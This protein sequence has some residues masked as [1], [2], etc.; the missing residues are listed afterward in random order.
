MK[1]SFLKVA[2]AVAVGNNETSFNETDFDIEEQDALK[3]RV[4]HKIKKDNKGKP[5]HAYTS[6][7]NAVYWKYSEV[8]P[9]ESKSSDDAGV[10]K[11]RSG[12]GTKA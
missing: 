2:Q 7:F 3:I 4:T 12:R 6:L 11:Q 9:E 10:V 5:L 1:L 8:Q